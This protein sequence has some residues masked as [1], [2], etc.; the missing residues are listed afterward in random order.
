MK[1]AP[2]ISI[3]IR[4]CH[5]L[6]VSLA[7]IVA[8]FVLSSLISF[9]RLHSL[10]V[11]NRLLVEDM[12]KSIE[13]VSRLVHDLDLKRLLIE[14]HVFERDNDEME[15]LETLIDA[16]DAD[17]TVTARAYEPLVTLPGER[18]V[19]EEL[20]TQAAALRW[21]IKQVL[22]FSRVNHDTEAHAEMRRLDTAFAALA[23]TAE[24]LNN[25]NHTEAEHAVLKVSE[26]QK[27][28]TLYIACIALG[29]TLLS[30]FGW[31]ISSILKHQGEQLSLTAV[32]LE[33]RNRELDAFSSR[34]AHDLRGPLMAIRLSASNF[35]EREPKEERAVAVLRRAVGQMERLIE[36]LLTLSRL[37]NQAPCNVSELAMVVAEVEKD[38]EPK[39]KSA[40]GIL[41]ITVEPAGV[42]C[43][44]GLL[45]QVLWNLGENAVNY[46]RPDVQL[47]IDIQGRT[48]GS[49]YE[50]RVSD[51]GS[52]MSTLEARQAFE[53]FFR[54]EHARSI[55]GTGLGLSIVRR[56]VEGC[57]GKVSIDSTTGQGTT[58]IIHLL[59]GERG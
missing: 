50:L 4:R 11:T 48:V 14:T 44:E 12:L 23:A 7:F 51:N 45:R 40:E 25:F 42:R 57:G 31:W 58:F 17:F 8:G 22:E 2:P 28:S 13:Y 38:L 6:R 36:D 33:E 18:V 53:P 27:R 24:A 5:Q 21:P 46:R 43:S 20:K 1:P 19:W 49:F 29:G 16:A 15:H 59:C 39:V 26:L 47:K 10:M 54:G 41:S 55:A 35:S 3:L 52:G 37:G 32:Q 9:F 34:V 56:I 30:L